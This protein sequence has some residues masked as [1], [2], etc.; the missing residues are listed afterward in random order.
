[1]LKLWLGI[2]PGVQKIERRSQGFSDVHTDELTGF[3]FFQISTGL[4]VDAIQGG[5]DWQNNTFNLAS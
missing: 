3:C 1:M 5:Y 2:Y 4:E